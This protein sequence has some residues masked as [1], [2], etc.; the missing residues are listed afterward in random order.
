M[1][2][3][4]GMGLAARLLLVLL[5]P[6]A[7]CF[8]AFGFSTVRLRRQ[9]MTEEAEREN[10]DHGIV[11]QLAFDAFLRDHSLEDL[12][13]LAEDL[14]RADRILGVVIFDDRDRPVAG[15]KAV[16]S[17]ATEL[18][19]IAR[20]ARTQ[21]GPREARLRVDGSDVYAYAFATGPQGEPVQNRGVAVMLRDLGYIEANLHAFE[22]EIALVSAL[23]MCVVALG[24]WAS[25]R[26]LVARPL[27]SLVEGVENVAHGDLTVAIA[28]Q[29][30]DEIGRLAAAFNNMTTSLRRARDELETKRLANIALERRAQHAQRLALVGQLTATVAH[31]IGSPL[32]VI[33]G[34]ARYALRGG[35]QS[36]R[37]RR[38]FQEIAAGADSI[39]RVIEGLLSQARK[40]RGP[41]ESVDLADVAYDMFHFLEAECERLNIQTSI[42]VASGAFIEGRR[43]EY[44]QLVLN[45]CL[46]AIQAQHGGGALTLTVRKNSTERGDEV[47]VEVSD[48]GPGV[49]DELKQQIFEPF[50]TTKSS[51]QGTGLGLAICDEIVRR[52]GGSIQ[53]TDGTSGGALF[54]V[55]LPC[56]FAQAVDAKSNAVAG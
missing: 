42:A 33:L 52:Q 51:A 4:Q 39:S 13:V 11:L 7:I 47:I 15:S 31:Q 12:S 41:V 32:N 48:S 16:A 28:V 21:P 2:R 45:L 3:I 18:V 19:T 8:A 17:Y 22:R 14:S 27:S 20:E 34:R 46:N 55:T 6:I 25:M 1:V 56:A 5:V 9:L 37:D 50:F 23:V 43:D 10:R 30:G 38:H 53:V 49:P 35:G 26:R 36:E 40:A 44:E 54:R 24:T 29:R